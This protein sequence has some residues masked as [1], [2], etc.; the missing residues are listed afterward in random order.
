VEDLVHYIPADQITVNLDESNVAV[1]SM[2]MKFCMPKKIRE[3]YCML[4]QHYVFDFLPNKCKFYYETI[5][6]TDMA[7]A[8]LAIYH[9]RAARFA[10]IGSNGKE[11]LNPKSLNLAEMFFPRSEQISELLFNPSEEEPSI[12]FAILDHKVK[13]LVGKMKAW[14]K[15]GKA[16]PLS[17]VGLKM[18]SSDRLQ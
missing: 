13:A 5:Q 15:D 1:T 9:K 12:E 8:L 18:I 2:T 4:L 7:K 16:R 17:E 3:S 14:M 10:A 6:P 11:E